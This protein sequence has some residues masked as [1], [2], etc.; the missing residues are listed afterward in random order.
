MSS[1]R[2]YQILL[3]PRVTEKTA[4][5]GDESNQYVFKVASGA[6]KAEIRA[7]VEKLF[8][9]NVE[10]V[11]VVNVKGKTKHSRCAQASVAIGKK[12]MYVFRKARHWTSWAE[13]Q[14][15]GRYSCK[16]V[17]KCSE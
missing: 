2:L 5:I 9:V 12:P 17:L 11:R 15:K 8:E 4:R 14:F 13:N 16:V 10:A 3:A 1:D 6:N 7:A